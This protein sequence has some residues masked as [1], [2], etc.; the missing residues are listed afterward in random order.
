MG[1]SRWGKA[2]SSGKAIPFSRRSSRPRDQTHR[3]I[4]YPL[5]HQESPLSF[6]FPSDCYKS[7]PL[8]ELFTGFLPG[9][10]DSEE[11]GKA[12]CLSLLLLLMIE[13]KEIILSNRLL[14][15]MAKVTGHYYYLVL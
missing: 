3:Q 1:F 15:L 14:D 5:S 10:G 13:D 6:N 7:G 9:A 4:L 8:P 12:G 2:I 11:E